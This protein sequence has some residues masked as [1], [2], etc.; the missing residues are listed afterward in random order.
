M[1]PVMV[2]GPVMPTPTQ[3]R[4]V[5]IICCAAL[6]N[7]IAAAQH[8]GLVGDRA[9][10]WTFAVSGD[11]RNCGNVVMPAIAAAVKSN[12]GEFYWHLGDYRAIYKIDEDYA[13]EPNVARDGTTP[14][15]SA[16][17]AAAWDDFISHQLLPFANI[18]VYLA[19]G[20]HETTPPKTHDD[21]LKRFGCWFDNAEL[22]AQRLKD[23]PLAT[24]PVAYFHWIKSGVDFIS[25]DN[26][27]NYSFDETQRNWLFSVVS[28]DEVDTSIRSIVVGMHEALP[29]SL[30]AS[31]SMCSSAEGIA[32]GR[33][34]YKTLVHA[35]Q[36][37]HKNVYV[38]ASH[39]HFYLENIYNTP[40]WNDP[41]NGGTVL[42]GW[43][44]GTAGAVR[45][46]LPT[47]LPAGTVSREHVYGYLT[48]TVGQDGGIVFAFQ[49]LS[50]D[51]LQK[52]RSKDYSDSFV[53][54]C[55]EENPPVQEMTYGSG[56]DP[57]QERL[58]P[59]LENRN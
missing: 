45:Y 14:T 1:S 42:P 13:V 50:E 24:S 22:K 15:R 18:P 52:A 27:V 2:K 39:S 44:I 11:S 58:V 48:G 10:S 32:S 19:P 9:Q 49:C 30:S 47:H 6:L 3:L 57:C 53:R 23:N 56:D 26:S 41:K 4:I 38:L 40:Y 21:Y 7:N 33:S 36:V 5:P 35:M 17:I 20:N 25:L 46:K 12:G 28:R 54:K 29:D 59:P 8:P 37:A 43:I 51:A 31:H 34:V 16:Y 55:F